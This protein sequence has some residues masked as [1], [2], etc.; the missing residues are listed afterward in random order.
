P[1]PL[2]LRV[3]GRELVFDGFLR[4]YTEPT[5]VDVEEE[6]A[7]THQIPLLEQG[8]VLPVTAVPVAEK[9]TRAPARYSEASLVQTLEQRG[10][11]RPSTFASTIQVLK[12]RGYIKLS[13]KRLLPSALGT[14]L[15]AFLVT[16]FPSLFAYDYTAK[17]EAK[18][19]QIASGNATRLAILQT[20][21]GNFQPLLG[22]AT[23]VTLAQV[24]KRH[25][26][27]LLSEPCLVCDDG[28]LIQRTGKS[29]AFIGCTNYPRC[30]HTQAIASKPLVLR[31]VNEDGHHE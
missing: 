27:R 28:E 4:V 5:D 10:I 16:H 17:L 19:D 22:R 29:G 18:L 21:W 31:P 12:A 30:T 13:K 7:D 26:E 24:A 25:Q 1:F 14:D 11:G 3:Q 2:E 23:E 9:Q 6:S 8:Q 15:N 20:F